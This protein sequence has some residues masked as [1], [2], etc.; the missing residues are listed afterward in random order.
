MIDIPALLY[1]LCEDKKVLQP[2][3]EL[4]ESGLL[5]SLAM[6]QLFMRLEDC[7]V[8]L[9]PTQI[10]RADLKTPRRIAL[11]VQKHCPGAADSAA[12]K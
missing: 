4:L 10:N 5:D 7:G 12:E 6:M 9:Q 8:E 2:D 1:E 11:L 3:C